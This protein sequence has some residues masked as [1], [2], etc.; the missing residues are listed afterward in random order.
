M[1]FQFL[2]IKE[3]PTYQVVS[4]LRNY[5][6][7]HLFTF[8]YLISRS[9]YQSKSISLQKHHKLQNPLM[10]TIHKF[11]EHSLISKFIYPYFDSTN[12]VQ[13]HIIIWIEYLSFSESICIVQPILFV[14]ESTRP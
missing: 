1:V 14:R 4:C 9:Y 10:E 5:F 3:S 8:Q 11:N 6:F 12:L 7:N 2:A 13:Y